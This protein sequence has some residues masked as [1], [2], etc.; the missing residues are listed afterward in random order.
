MQGE[1]EVTTAA[2]LLGITPRHLRALAARGLVVIHSRGLTTISSAV[3][4]YARSLRAD[5]RRSD[6][7]TAAARQHVAKASVIAA[8]T[9]KRRAALSDWAE[10]EAVIRT[11]AQTAKD[12]LTG[13]DATGLS[14]ATARALATEAEAAARR[15]EKTAAEIVKGLRGQGGRHDETL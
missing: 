1:I 5:A 3:S 14:P 13:L 15:I 2:A 11:V 6:A 9:A 7:S 4:G 12:A 8:T 10:T